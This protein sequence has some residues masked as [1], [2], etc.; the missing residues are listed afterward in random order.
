MDPRVASAAMRTSPF[1]VTDANRKWWV[2]VAMTGSLSM[3]LLD[4]TMIGVALPTIQRELDLPTVDLQWV[5][6][7]YLLSLAAFVS[8]GGRLADL[9]GPVRLYGTGVVVFALSSAAAGLAQGGDVLIAARAVQGIGAAAMMPASL[10][11]VMNAFDPGEQGRAVGL[12]SG[13]SSVFLTLGP[14]LGGLLTQAVSWRAIFWVNLP[15]SVV[16]LALTW[17]AHPHSDRARAGVARLERVGVLLLVPGL[18]ATVVALMEAAKWGWG[19][20][21]TIVLLVTGAG[22]LAA[23]VFHEW[24]ARSRSSTCACSARR[25]LVVD[26]TVVFVIQ[27]ALVGLTVWGHPDAGP[28]RLRAGAGRL[29]DRSTTIAI[30]LVAPLAGRLY[31]RVGARLPLALGTAT[32]ALGLA[33]T[34]AVIDRLSY[35]WLV[36]GYTAIEL[37]IALTSGPATVDAL[38]AAGAALRGQAAGLIQLVRQL[39]G[40]FGLAVI[41]TVV[42]VVQHDRLSASLGPAGVD[43]TTSWA[44]SASSPRTRPRAG[45]SRRT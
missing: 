13:V 12:R 10:A 41:G 19:S 33:W 24:H 30:T 15:V 6:N 11:I 1:P 43:R 20:P 36:P 34:G 17:V 16:T 25:A 4:T 44:S 29:G 40:V 5:V 7:A 35:A 2:L 3:V 31:D 32:T 23:F 45:R 26:R 28:A 42:A 8:V 14:V 9:V 38:T 27:F 18:G 21:A 39:G 22:L 37:G